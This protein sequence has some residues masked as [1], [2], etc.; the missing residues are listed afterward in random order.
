L[1]D[2]FPSVQIQAAKSL[3]NFGECD[4]ALPLIVDKL[5][6]EGATML[7]GARAIQQLGKAAK[8][9]LNEVQEKQQ[10]LCEIAE[11]RSQYYELYACWA[12]SEWMKQY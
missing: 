6:S 3:C 7:M 8:P 10:R 12:L 4:D 11:D 1:N 5:D 9:V 2:P